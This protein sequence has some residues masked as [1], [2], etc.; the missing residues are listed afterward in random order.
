MRS[1]WRASAAAVVALMVLGARA[2]AA[3]IIFDD[4]SRLDFFS[5]RAAGNSPL[6]DITVSAATVI[7][8]IGVYNDLTADG[9]LK[10]LIF[11]LDTN[12]LLFQ[13][14]TQAFVD[15]GASFKLSNVFAPFVLLPGVNYGIGAIADVAAGWGIN[16]SSGGNPFTQN[17]I[18]AS[19][20]RNGNVSNFAAPALGAE[21]TAMIIVQLGN[22]AAPTAVPEPGTLVLLGSAAAWMVRRRRASG[23]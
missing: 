8:E 22:D 23:R 18:T 21:G 5:N 15:N 17:G 16:N 4:V 10:F 3:S 1:A 9:N 11:N 20:D 19:D 7:T 13:S 2:E 6:A 12:T 14:A